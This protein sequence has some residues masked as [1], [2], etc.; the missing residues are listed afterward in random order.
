M[1]SRNGYLNDS[2]RQDALALMRCLA[3]AQALV[4]EG[5]RDSGRLL[6][7][8]RAELRLN[9]E[10]AVDYVAVV[11]PVDFSPALIVNARSL[12][13]VAA[14]VGR[15][16]LIDNAAVGDTDLLAYLPAASGARVLEEAHTWSA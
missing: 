11:D 16:R 2:E 7:A 13:L 14:R 3:R 5:Q 1:S 4:G 8:M 9:P 12:A 10:V 6:A 15:A